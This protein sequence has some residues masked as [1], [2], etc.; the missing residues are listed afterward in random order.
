LS[1]VGTI[2]KRAALALALGRTEDQVAC[3]LEEALWEAGPNHLTDFADALEF[4]GKPKV[5]EDKKKKWEALRRFREEM[6][7]F[8][9]KK[10][11]A[12]IGGVA[13]RSYGGRTT[14]TIDYDVLVAPKLLK[15]MTAF[16]EGQSG[17]LKGTVENTY[18]FHLKEPDLRLDVRVARSP[19][20]EEA[21]ST[22]KKSTFEGRKLGIVNPRALA[23]MKVKAYSE[24]KEL[25]PGAQ[26]R[27]DVRGLIDVGATTDA[28]IR[29]LLK[30]HRP[31]LLSELDEILKD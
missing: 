7:K 5:S 17:S 14:P 1:R 13:V 11:A 10:D 25:P 21:L 29:K 12:F 23:A 27:A 16:L 19:L 24:R 28:E 26:V 4:E 18:M 20:D 30:K 31:D 8:L 2:R 15:S 6:T 3:R 22:A 9:E